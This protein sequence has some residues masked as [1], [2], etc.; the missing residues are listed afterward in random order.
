M[1]GLLKGWRTADTCTIAGEGRQCACVRMRVCVCVSVCGS[2]CVCTDVCENVRTSFE[3]L[4]PVTHF[5]DHRKRRPPYPPRVRGIPGRPDSLSGASRATFASR[6]SVVTDTRPTPRLRMT[7]EC[8][9]RVRDLADRAVE[10]G[11]ATVARNWRRGAARVFVPRAASPPELRAA[12]AK[13]SGRTT[14]RL[15]FPI[16]QIDAKSGRLGEDPQPSYGSKLYCDPDWD[17]RLGGVKYQGLVASTRRYNVARLGQVGSAYET[18]FQTNVALICTALRRGKVC[19]EGGGLVRFV[20][21]MQSLS[22]EMRERLPVLDIFEMLVP[23]TTFNEWKA[24]SRISLRVAP[25]I[26][27]KERVY[28]V[29]PRRV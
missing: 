27:E 10:K 4:E 14:D 18:V 28:T 29:R 22:A 9:S 2:L 23:L 11:R 6:H 7:F 1:S 19:M 25:E 26:D 12:N 21:P 17:A 5:D 8:V 15:V 20:M 3:R 16:R 13:R 24:I